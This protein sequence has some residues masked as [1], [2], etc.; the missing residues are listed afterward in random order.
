[1]NRIEG[2]A[3]RKA[4]LHLH[5]P[6]SLCFRDKTV[7]P[8][9]IVERA[10][11]KGLDVIAITDHNTVAAVDDIVRAAENSNLSIF[12]GIEVSTRQGH[13]VALFDPDKPRSTLED[14]LDCIGIDGKRRGD[15]TTSAEMGMEAV[16]EKIEEYNGIAIAAHIER[17]P[18]GFLETNQPRR[19]KMNI[20]G[21]PNLSVLEIT[22]SDNKTQWNTGRVRGYPK[23][24]ACIQASDAHGLE[25]IGRRPVYI[26]MEQVNLAA[27]RS[28]FLDY[29]TGVV[30]PN[31]CP[32]SP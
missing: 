1:M 7:T 30:F 3:F 19:V 13:V 22:I 16:C 24:Y 2:V 15:A 32:S 9:Q 12:P 5:T 11:A 31:G 17:W 28:A 20:H 18:S 23:K 29:E 14:L 27:L 26:R 25:E 10:L 4:D 8:E 6:E 21:N